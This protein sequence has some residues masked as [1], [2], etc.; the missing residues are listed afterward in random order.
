MQKLT[1]LTNIL[2][3]LIPT[4]KGLQVASAKQ[5]M[6]EGM[7][8]GFTFK[9]FLEKNIYAIPFSSGYSLVTSVDYVRKIFK[10]KT[11]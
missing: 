1:A 3:I 10:S 5:A 8:R 2:K 4:F 6:L 9:D 11:Q 7:M